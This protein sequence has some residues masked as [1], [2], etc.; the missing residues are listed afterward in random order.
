MDRDEIKAILDSLV[1]FKIIN[2]SQIPDIDLYMDQVLTFIED[3]LGVYR[4]S[5][6]EKLLTKTMINNYTKEGLIAPPVKKKYSREHIV[7]LIMLYHL[8]TVLS[9]GDIS[10]LLNAIPSESCL[11]IYDGFIAMQEQQRLEAY[12]ALKTS[13]DTVSAADSEQRRAAAV[14][15]VFAL[16]LEADYRKQLAERLIDKMLKEQ[17]Q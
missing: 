17:Q 3:R 11:E 12:D 14:K 6:N 4:R 9:I 5:D 13:T 7:R 2:I 10:A 1:S 16:A 15:A 8:K